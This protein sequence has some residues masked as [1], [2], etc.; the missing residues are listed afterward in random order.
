MM[1]TV[2]LYLPWCRYLGAQSGV[3][4]Q[5]YA[6]N[7]VC[8]DPDLLLRAAGCT[9]GFVRL[10]GQEPARVIDGLSSW[11]SETWVGV[12]ILRGGAGL[13]LCRPVFVLS[14]LVLMQDFLH[15][16]PI[17]DD[18]NNA[19]YLYP[20]LGGGHRGHRGERGRPRTQPLRSA[21]RSGGHLDTTMR[22]WSSTLSARVCLVMSRLV[23]IFILPLDFHGRVRVVRTMFIPCALRC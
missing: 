1:F 10:G 16:G 3:S 2:A 7:L 18:T 12:L 17:R 20:A 5:L 8:R 9:T 11:M 13:P 15:V 4:P 19:K 23:L 14:F 6:D 21:S 22:G